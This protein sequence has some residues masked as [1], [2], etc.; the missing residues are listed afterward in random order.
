MDVVDGSV[1]A[2]VIS[3]ECDGMAV[4]PGHNVDAHAL[5][6]AANEAS[7]NAGFQRMKCAAKECPLREMEACIDHLKKA[8]P[9]IPEWTWEKRD[10]NWR[11]VAKLSINCTARLRRNVV[12]WNFLAKLLGQTA[13]PGVPGYLICE[14]VVTTASS[15]D[16]LDFWVFSTLQSGGFWTMLP[17]SIAKGFLS[18]HVEH[19]L[20]Q[21]LHVESLSLPDWWAKYG[22]VGAFW[23]NLPA[24]LYDS[25]LMD[26]LDGPATWD[27]LQFSDG[28]VLHVKSGSVFP[29]RPELRIAKSMGIPYPV[30]YLEHFDG[31]LREHNIDLGAMFEELLQYENGLLHMPYTKIPDSLE[32]RFAKL[33]SLPEFEVLHVMFECFRPNY[34]VG[35]LRLVKVPAA[36][37]YAI[38]ITRF[39]LDLGQTGNNG[40]TLCQRVLEVLVG[41][42]G[43]QPKETFFTKEPPGPGQACPDLLDLKGRR[44]LFQP[45][46]ETSTVVRT[47]W[48][49]KLPDQSIIW[50][51][52]LLYSNQELSFRGRIVPFMSLNNKLKF[53]VVDGGLARRL[54]S[55][56]YE[57][58]F[59]DHVMEEFHRQALTEDVKSDEWILPR[60]PAY[61]YVLEK[62]RSH[63]FANLR[64]LGRIPQQ[65]LDLNNDVLGSEAS[66]AV[67]E[68][69]TDKLKRV[70]PPAG[71]TK[72]AQAFV[73]FKCLQMLITFVCLFSEFCH[74]QIL[75][76]V[77]G[78]GRGLGAK[79]CIPRGF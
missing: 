54:L 32:N 37:I 49:K 28:T 31:L 70:A 69:V 8:N 48:L 23:Q 45:E 3:L 67:S 22:C 72:K 16:G 21:L 15:K 17:A 30:G 42:Y 9:H 14:C 34:A 78:N 4:L 20:C 61:L 52:R 53:S 44:A 71:M 6:L 77:S 47:N 29:G 60:L 66:E 19:L 27:Y 40:K 39:V 46:V 79:N 11:T 62:A 35:L 5:V 12:P 38:P 74:I 73:C 75:D 26:T 63:Y 24:E 13:M 57:Y 18:S 76:N 64:G 41:S 43:Q 65:V 68:W 7:Q 59:V 1:N 55:I 51:A 56:A 25:N 50:K 2:E 33:F 36:V 10:M 58:T